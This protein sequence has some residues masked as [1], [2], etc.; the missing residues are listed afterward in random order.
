MRCSTRATSDGAG[1]AVTRPAL[2]GWDISAE[3]EVTRHQLAGCVELLDILAGEGDAAEAAEL[4][5][6]SRT[7]L[8]EAEDR[9]RAALRHGTR[10]AGQAA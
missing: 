4:L 1:P 6:H 8:R 9:V 5:R 2:T 3:V 7:V 10:H